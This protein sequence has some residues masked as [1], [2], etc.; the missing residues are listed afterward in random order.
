MIE[1]PDLQEFLSQEDKP[2]TVASRN[3]RCGVC[4]E[5]I[6][7]GDTIVLIDGEWCHKE[8]DDHN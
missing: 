7:E 3:S 1:P 5:K 2:E 8:C 4:D 6:Y